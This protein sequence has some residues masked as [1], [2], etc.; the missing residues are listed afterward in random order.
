MKHLNDNVF[1]N[2][3]SSYKGIIKYNIDGDHK[4]TKKDPFL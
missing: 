2:I 3:D 1:Q 4:R